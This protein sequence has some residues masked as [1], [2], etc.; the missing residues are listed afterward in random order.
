MLTFKKLSDKDNVSPVQHISRGFMLQTPAASE[1][2][3]S[4][5]T[6]GVRREDIKTALDL[7]SFIE[8]LDFSF[9]PQASAPIRILHRLSRITKGVRA[10]YIHPRVKNATDSYVIFAP[11]LHKRLEKEKSECTLLLKNK[12]GEFILAE[13]TKH[14]PPICMIAALAAHEVRHRVQQHFKPKLFDPKSLS[15]RNPSD[16]LSNAVCVAT[17]LIEEIRKSCKQRKE[18]KHVM[19]MMTCRKELDA[20]VIEITAL[21]IFYQSHSIEKLIPLIRAGISQAV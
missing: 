19:Q 8:K 13:S 10:A 3:A 9:F 12:G 15:E 11:A 5:K 6:K 14:I 20:L 21:H 17:L 4:L 7:K 18:R 1:I 16:L 2:Q